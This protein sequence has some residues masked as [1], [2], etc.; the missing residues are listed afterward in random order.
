MAHYVNSLCHATGE[1]ALWRE[2]CQARAE[3]VAAGLQIDQ[4]TRE[5]DA[6][7]TELD[8]ARAVIQSYRDDVLRS[9]SP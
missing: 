4:L 5:R 7:V 9:L 6:A 2:L 8:T 3:L 1:H